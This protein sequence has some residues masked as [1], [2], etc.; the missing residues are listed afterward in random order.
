MD[1]L[2][3]QRVAIYARHSTHMQTG[4]AE[5]Q[6]DRCVLL[7]EQQGGDVAAVYSDAAKTGAT[8]A[9]RKELSRLVSDASSERYDAVLFEDLSRLSRDIAD[10]ATVFRT[11]TFAGIVLHSVTEG[12][13]TELHIGL[14]GTMNALFLKDIS[15]KTRRG[16]RASV[17]RGRILNYCYGYDRIPTIDAAG[18][19][20]TGQARINQEEAAVVRRIFEEY[21]AGK[22]IANIVRDLNR[23]G[24][25]SP[26]RREVVASRFVRRPFP[27][28]RH[29][30]PPH[31]CRGL[32]LGPELLPHRPR[33]RQEGPAT[34]RQDRMGVLGG[35]PPR[36]H[37]RGALGEGA[38]ATGARHARTPGTEE[39]A[40]PAH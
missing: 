29:P 8:K 32:R 11:L 25:P 34:D 26:S 24:I 40:P 35:T 39:H 31:L 27:Q 14:K 21:A 33:N 36:D 28:G 4:S 23:D 1:S 20:I 19:Q 12:R 30:P 38:G 6:V 13:I 18:N 22:P 3:G 7:V 10:T 9:P 37:R 5:D 15:D 2:S 16:L 17:K